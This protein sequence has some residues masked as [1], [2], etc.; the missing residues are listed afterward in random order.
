MTILA[1]TLG[2]GNIIGIS[3]AITIGG[4]GSIF[5]IFISGVFCYCYKIYR[6]IYSA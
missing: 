2:T 1:G 5:W 6:D 4:I 3:A